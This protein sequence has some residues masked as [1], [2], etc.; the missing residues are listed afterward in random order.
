M[1]LCLTN[2]SLNPQIWHQ[3]LTRKCEH[4]IVAN[5]KSFV[6]AIR[7]QDTLLIS[8]V[9]H[10]SDTSA[11][12]SHLSF[13]IA[14]SLY[15]RYPDGKEYSAPTL[16]LCQPNTSELPSGSTAPS[17][18]SGKMHH[19]RSD[20]NKTITGRS[21]TNDPGYSGAWRLAIFLLKVCSI[22]E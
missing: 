1:Y 18:G 12:L 19:Q 2:N 10:F 22:L 6:L 8:D 14:H 9:Y 15:S 21:P 13:F 16:S 3:L 17:G 11:S 5:E 20:S 4:S 7:R